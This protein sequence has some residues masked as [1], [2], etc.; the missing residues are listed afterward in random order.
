MSNYIKVELGCGQTKT[1]GFIG[2]DR[3]ELDGVD[4]VA[5]LNKGIPLEDNSVDLILAIHSLEHLDNLDNIMKEIYRVCKHKALVCIVAPYSNTLLNMSNP[6][7]KIVFNEHTFRFYTKIKT[8]NFIDNEEY[9]FPNSPYWGLRGSDNSNLNIDIRCI[10]IEFFYFPEYELMSNEEQRKLRRHQFDI[11]DEIMY[12]LLIVKK[13]INNTEIKEIIENGL[14]EPQHITKRKNELEIKKQNQKIES[15]INIIKKLEEE[16][17]SLKEQLSKQ[18]EVNEKLHNKFV[19]C[20][21]QIKNLKDIIQEKD[22]LLSKINNSLEDKNNKIKQLEKNLVEKDILNK[23]LIYK[24][25]EIIDKFKVWSDELRIITKRKAYYFGNYFD[26]FKKFNV[27]FD[28]TDKEFIEKM[29]LF[30]YFNKKGY[31]LKFT[32]YIPYNTY[33]E[34]K[35]LLKSNYNKMCIYLISN[36]ESNIFVEFVKENTIIYQNIVKIKEDGKIEID[37]PSIEGECFVRFKVMNSFEL[38]RILEWYKLCYKFKTKTK[39]SYYLL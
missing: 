2:I 32:D 5:D 9:F 36:I 3:Y 29:I 20:S 35:I 33:L 27:I 12:H 23:S 8:N 31:R 28:I 17:L 16:N 18:I 25:N 6:Y 13:E 37:I 34:Y 26:N 7:H 1:P 24:N 4:I 22:F 14:F 21:N 10:N 11:C 30:D 39:L 15:K 19:E 38:I